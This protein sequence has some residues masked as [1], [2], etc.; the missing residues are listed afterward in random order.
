MMGVGMSS[1]AKLIAT[2]HVHVV[3]LYDGRTGTIKYLHT[4]TTLGKGTPLSQLEAVNQ[5]KAHAARRAVAVDQLE[6]A[7]SEDPTHALSAHRIDMATKNFVPSPAS[8]A[9]QTP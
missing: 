6:T 2:T 1:R 7:T 5:A 3:A 4:V 9:D 8:A